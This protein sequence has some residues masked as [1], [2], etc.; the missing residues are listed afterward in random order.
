[1]DVRTFFERALP[2]IL[3]TRGMLFDRGRGVV[4]IIVH[5]AGAWT[6]R[7]GDH[8]AANAI[9]ETLDLEADLVVTWTVRQFEELFG[10]A[11][12]PEAVRPV[13]MGDA[14]LL[15][16]L[17]NLLLPPARGGLGARMMF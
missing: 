15:S 14:S 2:D 12:E 9:E 5:G 13:H 17:G 3:K 7:F 1:M 6:L 11:P 4:C 8:K 10:G 16:Q